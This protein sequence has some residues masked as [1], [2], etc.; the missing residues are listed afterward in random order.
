MAREHA[1][2]GGAGRRALAVTAVMPPLRTE[3]PTASRTIPR[4]AQRTGAPRHTTRHHARVRVKQ[5]RDQE[6]RPCP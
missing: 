1:E 2:Q 3:P 6:A 5:S 4:A